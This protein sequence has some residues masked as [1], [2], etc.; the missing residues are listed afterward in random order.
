LARKDLLPFIPSR[1]IG[2][3]A[4]ISDSI[5][6]RSWSRPCTTSKVHTSPFCILSTETC[7]KIS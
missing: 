4:L 3:L 6:Y 5:V 2:L 1:Y 7:L